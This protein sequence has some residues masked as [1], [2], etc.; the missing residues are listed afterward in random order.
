MTDT[1]TRERPILFKSEMIRAIIG[2]RKT[3]TRR[4]V[5]FNS[6]FSFPH[7]AYKFVWEHPGGGWCFADCVLKKEEQIPIDEHGMLCPYGGVG[8]RLWCREAFCLPDPNDRS[9][10]CYRA[11]DDPVTNGEKWRS[12]IHMPRG[13]WAENSW[14]WA[15]SFRKITT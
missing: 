10:V 15:I 14:V 6:S 9:I 8:D 11:S 12:P 4:I 2:N 5:N 1:K 13:S 7:I 3:Q